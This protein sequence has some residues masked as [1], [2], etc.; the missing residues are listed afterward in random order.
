MTAAL[1]IASLSKTF[2]G[3]QALRGVDFDIDPGEVHALV[4]QNG[5]GKSTLIK[6][7]AGYETLDPGASARVGE[8]PLRLGDPR[9]AAEACLC[10]V[11]QDLALVDTMSAM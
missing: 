6:I 2:E 4:G 9:S 5:S 1:E 10:F 3:Q 8:T 11:H 7:L